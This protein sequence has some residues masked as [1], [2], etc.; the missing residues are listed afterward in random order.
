MVFYPCF[1]Q[2][3]QPVH[4][5]TFQG[6]L[7]PA[8]LGGALLSA[9]KSLFQIRGHRFILDAIGQEIEYLKRL[10]VK[11]SWKHFGVLILQ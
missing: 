2:E 9:L 10:V 5:W 7:C 11:P 6:G 3:P 1:K 8:D 4:S